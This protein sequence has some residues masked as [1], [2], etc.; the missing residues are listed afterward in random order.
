[1]TGR[2]KRRCCQTSPLSQLEA[3]CTEY[4]SLGTEIIGCQGLTNGCSAIGWVDNM[5]MEMAGNNWNIIITHIHSHASW[6][7]IPIT[8]KQTA[9][10]NE[11]LM[12]II[13]STK[14]SRDIES[15]NGNEEVNPNSTEYSIK[16]VLQNGIVPLRNGQMIKHLK[17]FAFLICGVFPYMSEYQKYTVLTQQY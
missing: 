2:C 9:V 14:Q 15:S 3:G 11:R 4:K 12:Q 16:Q 17:I 7:F 6:A 10:S 8:A 13:A 5:R 1:M